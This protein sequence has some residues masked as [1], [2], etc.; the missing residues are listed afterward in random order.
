MRRVLTALVSAVAALSGCGGD[1]KPAPLP[2]T[3]PGVGPGPSFRPPSLG[4][5]AARA[6]PIAGLRCTRESS[7]R[8]GVHLELFARRKVVLIP[9]GIGIAPPRRTSGAYVRAGR[10]S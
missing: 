5:R 3:A 6:Q 9:P 10:C 4:R 1:Y 7:A 8:Y 2:T